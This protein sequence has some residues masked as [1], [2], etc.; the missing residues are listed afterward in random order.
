MSSC[1]GFFLT[2]FWQIFIHMSNI[3]FMQE[4]LKYTFQSCGNYEDAAVI[5]HV[6]VK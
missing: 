4:I 6:K 2:C 3:E 5:S 1:F